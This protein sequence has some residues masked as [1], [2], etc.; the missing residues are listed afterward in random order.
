MNIFLIGVTLNIPR[1]LFVGIVIGI[2]YKR[3]Y[4]DP[5]QP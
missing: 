5:I 2:L 3:L 4:K 1:F